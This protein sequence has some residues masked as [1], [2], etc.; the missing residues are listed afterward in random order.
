MNK[1]HK[2]TPLQTVNQKHA[3]PDDQLR[4]YVKY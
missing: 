2:F 1:V 3:Y 4:E